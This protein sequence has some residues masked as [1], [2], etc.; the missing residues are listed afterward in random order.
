MVS[1]SRWNYQRL[2]HIQDTRDKGKCEDVN[3]SVKEF[4]GI[5]M[6]GGRRAL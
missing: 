1:N 5:V 6:M 2:N 4:A 3:E